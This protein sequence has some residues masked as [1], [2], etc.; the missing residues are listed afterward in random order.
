M[1]E[2]YD[3][4]IIGGGGAG[5]TAAL[6][7]AGFGKKTLMIEERQTGGEC[8]WSGCIPSKALLHISEIAGVDK[9]ASR[10]SALESV[11]KVIQ[12]VYA[13]ETPEILMEK[14]VHFV[15]GRALFTDPR[16]VSAGGTAYTAG[17]FI[18]A[19][20][21]EAFIP[22]IPGIETVHYL[23][24]ESFFTQEHLPASMI[25]LG[26]GAIGLELSQGM[27]RLGVDVSVLEV[28]DRF[29]YREDQ[30]AAGIICSQ[31]AEEGVLLHSSVKIIKICR[32][33]KGVSVSLVKNGT[34][35]TLEAES[36]LIAAGRKP[37]V[38]HMGLN[39]IGV[40]TDG[41]GI[42]V[43]STL[44]SSLP[45]IFAAGDCTG[46]YL[47]SHMA[48]YQGKT[49]AL[50][51]ILPFRK[52]LSYAHVPRVTFT[53][54][55]L[56]HTG[57]L[58]AELK[59][60]GRYYKSYFMDYNDFDRPRTSGGEEGLVKVFCS[61]KGLILGATIAGSR[62][63]EL[64]SELQVLKTMKI[65]FYKLQSVIHPYPVYSDVLRQLSKQ[66]YLDHIM[67][68]PFVRFISLFKKN[69]P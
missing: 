32:S 58:E 1:A 14:G 55:E 37:R 30:D 22:D 7:A 27:N 52:K 35:M 26:G 16:T 41:R 48:E 64:I 43:D 60:S 12:D 4:I 25:V 28:L 5:L 2:Q 20:G 31:L 36:L 53:T 68:N 46:P 10:L 33:L 19:S 40:R 15:N 57:A 29:L 6:T 38:Q 56:A 63:G 66:A 24:N 67:N 44:R 65:P 51:A 18:I 54:P 69:R 39:E 45:H 47:F 59:E 62:A 3:V 50:N 42:V 9:M 21:S 23:T 49:A 61:E 13:H 11:R 34:Q 17:K 8:T